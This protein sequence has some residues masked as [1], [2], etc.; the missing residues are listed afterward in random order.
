MLAG[1]NNGE[2]LDAGSGSLSGGGS[3]GGG[4]DGRHGFGAREL[5]SRHARRGRRGP[6]RGNH[7]LLLRPIRPEDQPALMAFHDRCSDETQYMRFGAHKPHLRVDEARYL[8]DVDDRGRGALVAVEPGRRD[9]IHGVGRWDG[10]N[11]TDA[12][13]AFVIEDS[14]Q[15]RGLGHQLVEATVKRA[16]AAGFTRLY[17]DAHSTN[18]RMRRLARQYGLEIVDL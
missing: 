4:S 9:S 8:C 18:H 17:L 1:M 3:L 5:R 13:V 16:R 6:S 14:Y 15:G 10:L 12:E 11:R 7:D 2:H